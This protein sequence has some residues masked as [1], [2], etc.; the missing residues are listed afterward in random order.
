MNPTSAEN[1]FKAL[2]NF[3][4]E[5]P[6]WGFADTGTR[7]GKYL[8]PAAATTIEEKLSDAGLVHA[9]TGASPTVA[10]H[11]L[12]DF[13]RGAEDA[14]GVASAAARH[15]IRI[16]AINPNLFQDQEYKFGSFG[17]SSEVIRKKALQH[18]LESIELAHRLGS[19][20]ISLWFAD[21]SNYPGTANIRQR[22]H[23]F[24]ENLGALHAELRPG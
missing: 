4:I 17:N 23:W 15:N 21:G 13:P 7:F 19:R 2:D 3:R 20:D 22:K 11:V 24:E 16:G 12:W 18:C 10:V 6:T 1:V 8:Q 9:L 14:D 5:L